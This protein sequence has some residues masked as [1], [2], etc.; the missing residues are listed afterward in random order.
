MEWIMNISYG[1]DILRSTFCIENLRVH[2]TFYLILKVV[3]IITKINITKLYISQIHAWKTTYFLCIF[4][5][6]EN[7]YTKPNGSMYHITTWRGTV[8]D[9]VSYRPDTVFCCR[10]SVCPKM[11]KSDW[12][13]LLFTG[14]IDLTKSPKPQKTEF[15]LWPHRGIMY[16]PYCQRR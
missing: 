8:W 2:K 4:V 9:G 7:K 12:I 13:F 6:M 15:S 5:L 16:I 10:M 14:V 3:C 11:I 1:D